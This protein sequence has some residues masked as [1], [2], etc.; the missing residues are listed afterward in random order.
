VNGDENKLSV[1]V[2]TY[3]FLFYFFYFIKI[4]K[5]YGPRPA[6]FTS[7]TGHNRKQTSGHVESILLAMGREQVFLL[8]FCFRILENII[9]NISIL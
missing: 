5:C 7:C 2:C 3:V 4:T 6:P 9:E 1:S 8:F